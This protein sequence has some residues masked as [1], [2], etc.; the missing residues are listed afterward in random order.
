MFFNLYKLLKLKI[1]KFDKKLQVF[2][3]FFC[4]LNTKFDFWWWLWLP[5]LLP[6]N[7]PLHDVPVGKSP[8]YSPQNPF[9]YVAAQSPYTSFTYTFYLYESYEY[10]Y[11][12]LYVYRTYIRICLP[13]TLSVISSYLP[14]CHLHLPA[15]RL[16][17]TY[18]RRIPPTYSTS[19]VKPELRCS[20][21][22]GFLYTYTNTNTTYLYELL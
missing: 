5:F 1:V 7:L 22:A 18:T 17:Y 16:S 10:V 8:T 3:L 19:G 4:F 6:T 15:Y 12:Y 21:E 9:V 14:S 11:V 20:A 2:T 13:L